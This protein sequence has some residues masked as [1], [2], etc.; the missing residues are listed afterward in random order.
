MT[1]VIGANDGRSAL[2]RRAA[3]A[4]KRT[5]PSGAV[6]QLLAAH[7]SG[8]I[9]FTCETAGSVSASF[10]TDLEASLG[11]LCNVSMTARGGAMVLRI[12]VDER[13]FA[14]TS[15]RSALVCLL[16]CGIAL[17]ALAAETVFLIATR[18]A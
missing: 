6:V 3:I 7:T 2:Q 9:G 5:L 1:T 11:H 18:V 14:R 10:G 15:M 12:T 8:E 4:I 16:T 13:P 17:G